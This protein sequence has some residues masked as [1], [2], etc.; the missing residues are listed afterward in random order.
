[1][2]FGPA[3][4]V[5]FDLFQT[6]VVGPFDDQRAQLSLLNERARRLSGG[7][8]SD[9]AAARLATKHWAEERTGEE[10]TLR[11]R[12]RALQ[13]R[14]ALDEDAT[15]ELMTEEMQL[16]Q[17][18]T[19]PS[20]VVGQWFRAA[21]AQGKTVC[22]VSDTFYPRDFVER[23]LEHHGLVGHHRLY[24]SSELGLLKSTGNLFRHVL[25]DLGVAASRV[26]HIGDHPVSD[27]R[28]PRELGMRT[29]LLPS[30]LDT[31][32][33]HA[34][35]A[36]FIRYQ[37]AKGE[38]VVR[39]LTARR[40]ASGFDPS[41]ALPSFV[42]PSVQDLGYSVFG[43]M[44]LAF[45]SWLCRQLER[46]GVDQAFFLARDGRVLRDAYERLR[47]V[48][49]TLPPS[50]YLWA[51]RRST[52]FPCVRERAQLRHL[53]APPPSPM[54]LG[55][56]LQ[57]RFA[58]TEADLASRAAGE[59]G[60]SDWS[61]EVRLERDRERVLAVLEAFERVVLRRAAQEREALLDYFA[62]RGLRSARTPA[63]VDIGHGGTL[64]RAMAE[65]L[66]RQDLRGYY[67]ATV[68]AI[69]SLGRAARSFIGTAS[70]EPQ[71][72]FDYEPRIQPF[73]LLF[74]SDE[75]S[76]VGFD[77]EA[78]NR[79]ARTLPSEADASRK[80][81][82]RALHAAAL[83]FVD[84]AVQIL[85]EAVFE[86]LISPREAM[87]PYRALL[88]RPCRADAEL[89]RGIELE[90][91]YSGRPRRG[92]V[93]AVSAAAVW[94]EGERALSGAIDPGVPFWFRLLDGAAAQRPPL[95]KLR[96]LLRDPSGFVRDSRF[97]SLRW[98]GKGR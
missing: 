90:N 40:F 67:F 92:V 94:P 59:F 58:L 13:R 34:R 37:D 77:G 38:R 63:V 79:V 21:L 42:G 54:P 5:S 24:L 9:F 49:P 44:L 91:A 85:G 53:L 16:E 29:L 20:A 43:P 4:V 23:L 45:S 72:L 50:V 83:E 78:G 87:A 65:L 48:R 33:L 12:Y 71:T 98:L 55:A 27:E 11:Q 3:D 41:R 89:F 1:M 82:A 73:E 61:A 51:S 64:Q 26:L 80:A 30:A 60:F 97:L 76:F 68:P 36:R 74:L 52:C 31:F 2:N 57:H 28:R 47:A 18:L 66:S 17:R 56:L 10:V 32:R 81:F 7:A 39:G 35:G 8:V 86:G 62:E 93:H 15:L 70:D 14:F 95:R 25:R 96:K 46:D 88:T 69:A 6:L 84:D 22:I 19:R 75:E